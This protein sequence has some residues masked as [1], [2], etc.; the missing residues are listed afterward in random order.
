MEN[1]R[2]G[3]TGK[4]EKEPYGAVPPGLFI[5]WIEDNPCMYDLGNYVLAEALKTVQSL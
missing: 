4:M 5:D 2:G 1:R 3:G